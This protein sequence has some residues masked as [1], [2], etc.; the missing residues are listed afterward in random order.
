MNIM[1]LENLIYTSIYV[2]MFNTEQNNMAKI[3][4]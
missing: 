4:K 3:I 1:N 2:H